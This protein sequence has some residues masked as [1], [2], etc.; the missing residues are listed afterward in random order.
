LSA[1]VNICVAENTSYKDVDLSVSFPAATRCKRSWTASTARQGKRAQKIPVGEWHT[2]RI[3]MTGDHILC[4]LDGE[5]MLDAK[6]NTFPNAGKMG[7][8][9]KS[10]ARTHV[11][12]FTVIGK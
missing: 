12:D 11:D 2:R 4:Y 3:K 10:D 8:W 1:L 9:S 7:L 6:D 5:N